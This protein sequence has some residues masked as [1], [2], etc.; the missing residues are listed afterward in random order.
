MSEPEK[1][2]R[3]PSAERL[4]QAAEMEAYLWDK[5]RFHR[6]REGE[7]VV[8]QVAALLA[9]FAASELRAAE[10]ALAEEKDRRMETV[11]ALESMRKDRDEADALSRKHIKL[12]SEAA[13]MRDD[14]QKER[15]AMLDDLGALLRALGFG[16]HARPISPHEVMLDCIRAVREVVVAEIA[17]R[18]SLRELSEYVRRMGHEHHAA[19]G[20]ARAEAT[21]AEGALRGIVALEPEP[22]DLPKDWREQIAAC[23]EC[24]RYKRHPIQ[25]GICN[26]HRRPLWDREKHEA[27]EEKRLGYRAKEIARAALR[28]SPSSE[29][30]PTPPTEEPR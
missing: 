23:A 3:A 26:L 14:M 4:K 7:T 10:S 17:A 25:Q 30:S 2:P 1:P 8:E 5:R 16:G 21:K 20:A 13:M 12:A 28:S 15:D 11:A 19:L 6:L 27:F 22:F 9:S 29:P 24:E 18:T